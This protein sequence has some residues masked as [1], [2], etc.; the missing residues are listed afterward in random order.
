MF[1]DYLHHLGIV[2]VNPTHGLRAPKKPARLPRALTPDEMTHFLDGQQA[3]NSSASGKATWQAAR[4]AA[5][6]ELL[7]ASGMRIS[8]MTQL[9]ISDIDM[10]AGVAYIARGKGGR[11]RVTPFGTAAKTALRAWLAARQTTA[12]SKTTALF[13]NT[14]GGRLSARAVQL[15]TAKKAQNVGMGGRVSPHV[16]RHSCASHFLQSSQDLR[17]TQE[18]LGHA[19]ISSTQI[20]T[21]LDFQNLALSY[22][23]AHPRARRPNKLP[24]NT[25]SNAPNNATAKQRRGKVV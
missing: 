18:L 21:R 9:N 5:M 16:L 7:Y 6:F 1:F 10:G 17:A 23:Q 4:D 15:R 20:Y 14:R 11:G 12:D 3:A 8:E 2:A 22:E 24:N 19:D 13:I 25:A